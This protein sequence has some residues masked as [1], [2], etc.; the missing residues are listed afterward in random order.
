MGPNVL[1]IIFAVIISMIDDK[2]ILMSH[3]ASSSLMRK[4]A[5]LEFHKFIDQNKRAVSDL[6][7]VR[8]ERN[9]GTPFIKYLESNSKKLSL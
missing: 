5:F 7:N 2:V 8:R 1:L 6:Y 4:T 9:M 3:S